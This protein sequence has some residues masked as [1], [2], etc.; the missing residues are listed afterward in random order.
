MLLLPLRV[1][2]VAASTIPVTIFISLGLLYCFNFELNT[3]TLAVLVLTLGMIVD[4]S[5]VIIDNYLEKI[6]E[7]MSR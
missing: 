4:N 6:G 2:L 7:G 3:V 1:A 5:I